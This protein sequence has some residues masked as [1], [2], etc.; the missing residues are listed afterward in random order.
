MAM[1]PIRVLKCIVNNGFGQYRTRIVDPIDP[2]QVEYWT[3]DIAMDHE[4]EIEGKDQKPANYHIL[5]MGASHID[6]VE[7]RTDYGLILYS[8]SFVANENVCLGT[9][10]GTEVY[11]LDKLEQL[12]MYGHWNKKYDQRGDL[13]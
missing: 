13:V 4:L 1:H 11:F 8:A 2:V 6:S 7:I 3:L 12:I 5:M 10:H 9:D